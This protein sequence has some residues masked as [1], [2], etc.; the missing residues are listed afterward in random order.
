LVNEVT[1]LVDR[2][3]FLVL[4]T[5]IYSLAEDG[6][7]SRVQVKFTLNCLDVELGEAEN[8]GEFSTL[9]ITG[10]KDHLLL[11][12]DDVS[13]CINQVSVLGD[14]A[15][16]QIDKSLCARLLGADL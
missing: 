2:A 5:A 4:E 11:C 7:S 10:I 14:A 13:L 6:L 3:G 8:L 9:K 16:E 1:L 12:I 15:A